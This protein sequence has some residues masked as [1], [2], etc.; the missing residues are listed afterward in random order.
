MNANVDL[1][2]EVTRELK[3]TDPVVM[4]RVSKSFL[5]FFP[6]SVKVC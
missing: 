3:H 5:I 4:G 2:D 1:K 6:C